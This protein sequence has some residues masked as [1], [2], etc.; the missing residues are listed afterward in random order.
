VSGSGDALRDEIALREASIADARAEFDAG[1]LGEAALAA[2][3]ARERAAIERCR[4]ALA[5][6]DAS[7][8]SPAA[9]VPK[10][11]AHRR[12]YLLIALGCFVAAAAVV[13]V[14]QIAPRQPGSSITGGITTATA[15]RVERLLAQAEIDQSAGNPTDALVAYDQV[16]AL[17]SRN[18]E[19]LTQSG[20]LSFSAGSA[21]TDLALVRL[22]ETRVARAVAISPR[23]P[24]ARLYYAIIAASTPGHRRLA[25]RQFRVFLRLHPSTTLRAV[26]RPWLV[27]LGLSTNA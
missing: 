10:A 23:D 25:L 8:G 26:A 16:L 2:L 5:A 4:Q 6:A 1:E 21:D 19:A 20:W 24:G 22:G 27:R 13:L 14:A 18:V 3:E 11:R 17:D 7:S 15:Q 9:V 12:R